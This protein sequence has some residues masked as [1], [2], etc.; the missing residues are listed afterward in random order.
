MSLFGF[1][2]LTFATPWLLLALGALPL[3]WWLLRAIPPAPRQVA[4]PAI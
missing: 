2:T 1:G 4:F 3:L